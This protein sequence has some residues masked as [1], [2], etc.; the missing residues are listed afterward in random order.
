MATVGQLVEEGRQQLRAAQI[1]PPGRE[2]SRLLAH[3]LGLGEVQVLAHGDEPV[4]PEVERDFREL[5]ARRRAGEPMAYLTGEREF[6]GRGFH[7]D[8]RVL[9]PRPET[10]HLIEHALVAPVPADACV[11]DVGTGS[12]CLA[13]TL[14]A[15]RPAWRLVATD[16]SLAALAVARTNARRHGVEARVRTIAADLTRGLVAEEFDLVVGN[17][18]Y[19]E[20]RV[21]PFL[22]PDVRDFE[23]RLALAGGADG[24]GTYRRLFAELAA[25]RAGAVVALEFG[26]GQEDAVACSAQETGAFEVVRTG[27]DLAGIVRNVVLRRRSG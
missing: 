17:L 4:A 13:V 9:I 27:S 12:G 11:L 14:A 10:E 3:L 18:P 2:S 23:P 15:E 16:L 8:A 7:V 26:F 6:F 5:V 19:V 24:L 25:L 22:P 20:E 1:E 21:V